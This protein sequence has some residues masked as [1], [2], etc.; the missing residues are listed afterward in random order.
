MPFYVVF[1]RGTPTLQGVTL[2]HRI[3]RQRLVMD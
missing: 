2:R 1:M 3:F